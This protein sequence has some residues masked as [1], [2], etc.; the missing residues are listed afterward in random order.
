MS[1]QED[2][3]DEPDLKPAPLRSHTAPQAAVRSQT[4][5]HSSPTTRGVPSPPKIDAN[6]F[7]IS[8]AARSSNKGTSN[9]QADLLSKLPP[10]LLHSM[11]ESFSVLDSNSTGTINAASVVETMHSL[12]LR[13]SNTTQF[14]PLGQAQQL[15]LPQYLNQLASILV[16]L[17]PQQELLNAFSAFD[18][19]DSGQ[20]DIAELRDALLNTAPDAGERALTERDI[21]KAMDG[22]TGRRILGKHAVGIAGIKGLDGRSTKK[23]GDVFRYQEF[24][25]NLTG[26]SGVDQSKQSVQAR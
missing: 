12:G 22:F 15:S 10:Q 11:R 20:I 25:W 21:D 6:P 1:E 26:S 17:S 7:S 3:D 24:V 2:D 18:D 23:T 16:E 9:P 19:D 8:A 14:F 5:L 13:E 4:E